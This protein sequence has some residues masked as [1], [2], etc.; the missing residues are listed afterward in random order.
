MLAQR[1]HFTVGRG[2]Y[3][4]TAGLQFDPVTVSVYTNN[5]IFSCLVKSNQVKLETSRSVILPLQ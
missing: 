3:N 4:C 1:T 5:D 2:K